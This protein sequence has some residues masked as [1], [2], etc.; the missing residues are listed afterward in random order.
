MDVFGQSA[1]ERDGAQAASRGASWRSNPFLL[2]ENMP[3]ATGESLAD[4]SGRH[5][6][7]QRG[8]EG[9]FQLG[10]DFAQRRKEPLTPALLTTLVQRRMHWL[11]SA[12]TPVAVLPQT[13]LQIPV[14]T[15]HARDEVG[16]N[17]NMERLE[18][19]ARQDAQLEAEFRSVV[20]RLRCQ[21]DLAAS[22]GTGPCTQGALD[23][24]G[25]STCPVPADESQ[26]HMH[27][28]GVRRVGWHYEYRG[29]RYDRLADA[30]AYAQLPRN[31]SGLQA[32]AH[33]SL[34]PDEPPRLP[35]TDELAQMAAWGIGFDAG[36]YR[37]GRYRYERLADAVAYAVHAAPAAQG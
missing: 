15:E 21:Y 33:A 29:Y 10:P 24:A 4:W 16:R 3:Q 8:F 36:I 18:H 26:Q 32:R 23:A 9:Y 12:R 20:E 35:G 13:L 25:P 30:M 7:W 31:I 22:Q 6:A 27:E 34:A 11:L 28:L 19:G 1:L 2:R 14:P 17:W 5:D 37:L